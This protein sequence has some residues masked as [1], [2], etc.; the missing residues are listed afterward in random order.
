MEEISVTDTTDTANI[1]YSLTPSQIN[2]KSHTLK[3][4]KPQFLLPDASYL[5]FKKYYKAC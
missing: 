5:T 2:T 4:H 3:V 1:K